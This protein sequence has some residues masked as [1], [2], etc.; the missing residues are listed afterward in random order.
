[1]LT[2]SIQQ[3][4]AWAICHAGKDIENR[5]WYTRVRG[6]FLIHAGKKVDVEAYD[7]IF[8]VFQI[9]P[10]HANEIERGGIVGIANII[11]CVKQSESPWFFGEFGFV[12]TEQRPL[13]FMPLRGKLWFFDTKYEGQ[14]VKLK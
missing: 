2:L 13:A 4:W 7:F 14:L 1:M 3:P 9:K 11:D 12:L 5:S 6:Q 8:K 10:P